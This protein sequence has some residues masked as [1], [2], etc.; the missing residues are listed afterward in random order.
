MISDS[1]NLCFLRTLNMD[2]TAIIVDDGKLI[3][4]GQ[5]VTVTICANEQLISHRLFGNTNIT[6]HKFCYV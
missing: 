5:T 1:I 6:F 3:F 2:F 4:S